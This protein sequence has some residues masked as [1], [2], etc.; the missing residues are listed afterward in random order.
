MGNFAGT[1]YDFFVFNSIHS[2]FFRLKDAHEKAP[3][4]SADCA[5]CLS[6]AFANKI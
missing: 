1:V 6:E 2:I 3:L 4:S 5:T